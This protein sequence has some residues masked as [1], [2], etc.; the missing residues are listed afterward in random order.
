MLDRQGQSMRITTGSGS[1]ERFG[2][3]VGD[4]SCLSTKRVERE[5]LVG[6]ECQA[7]RIATSTNSLAPIPCLGGPF[8][9]LKSMCRQAQ[10]IFKCLKLFK[11]IEL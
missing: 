8:R 7:D 6:A 3:G 2:L 5:V 1:Y 4:D 9:F 11:S 10:Y